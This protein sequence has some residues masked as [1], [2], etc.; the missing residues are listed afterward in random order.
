M[1]VFFLKRLTGAVVYTLIL[2]RIPIIFHTYKKIY[3]VLFAHLRRQGL[4]LLILTFKR[5]QLVV[6]GYYRTTGEFF[7]VS[8]NSSTMVL[9][10]TRL[11]R[12]GG[13]ENALFLQAVSISFHSETIS[14]R[15][16]PF[17]D[18][19]INYHILQK[20]IISEAM[21]RREK[22]VAK[23]RREEALCISFSLTTFFFISLHDATSGRGSSNVRSAYLYCFLL[24]TGKPGCWRCK[25]T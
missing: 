23:S 9:Y 5:L 20:S 21:E 14:M 22:N 19:T 11:G 10:N 24:R 1:S 3:R 15:E 2:R 12:E 13:K 6:V 7:L 17:A 8:A 16:G 25:R 4:K 18:F